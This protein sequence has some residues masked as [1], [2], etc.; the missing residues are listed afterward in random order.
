MVDDYVAHLAERLGPEGVLAIASDHGLV[1]SRRSLR[2]NRVLAEAGLLAVGPDG[3]IDLSRTRAVYH[4]G[5][6]GRVVVNHSGRPAGVVAPDRVDEVLEQAAAALRAAV[7][8]ESGARLFT[9]VRRLGDQLELVAA[10]GYDASARTDG[11]TAQ[12]RS[13]AGVHLFG[14]ERAEMHASFT[15]WGAGVAGGARLGVIR[16]LDVA[17]TVAALL[18]LEPP[19]D[20][21]GE[22]L[23]PALRPDAR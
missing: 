20:A 23:E 19:R 5:N 13:P 11:E 18:G 15:V 4:A 8:P 21:E 9:E 1:A 17:P 6:S 2:P 7:D 10:P 3:A 22:V 14:P 16:Q 12:A